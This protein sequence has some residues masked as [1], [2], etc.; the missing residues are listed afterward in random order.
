M[1]LPHVTIAGNVKFKETKVLSSGKQVTSMMI[2][3][4]DK[5][6]DGQY[7][8]L[9]IKAEFWE[10]DS[11]FVDQYFQDGSP[12]IVTGKLITNTF[13][14]NGAK[15]HEIKFH[16]PKASFVPKQIGEPAPQTQS[17]PPHN[18]PSQGHYSQPHQ[19]PTQN[20]GNESKSPP[21]PEIDIND[22]EIPF[23]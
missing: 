20:Q 22:S 2:S 7:D 11:K 19:A 12:I 1:S 16:F 10:Q 8:N 6:K 3:C 18:A 23:N 17:Q 14:S 13:E 15:R 9:N 5:R 21:I 4:S